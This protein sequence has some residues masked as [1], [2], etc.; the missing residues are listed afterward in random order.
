MLCDYS[1]GGFRPPEM[2]KRRPA[3][4][5]SPRLPYRDG[6]CSVVPISMTAPVRDVPYVVKLDFE[7]PLPEPFDSPVGWVK[8]D[9][10]A[11]VSFGR[12]DFFRTGRDQ[13][14]KRKYR[15]LKLS[16]EDFERVKV[17]ILN[18]LGFR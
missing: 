13:E 10:V 18:G 2:I 7:A 15:N 1:M 4:V 14:G 5:V 11:T 8:C 12:L 3:V 16:E 17:G 9:M 6:L